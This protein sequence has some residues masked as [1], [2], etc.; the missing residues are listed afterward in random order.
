MHFAWSSC[1]TEIVKIC[2][3]LSFCLSISRYADSFLLASCL[4][5]SVSLSLSLFFD[6]P[7]LTLYSLYTQ[8][9]PPLFLCR[10]ISSLLLLIM[11][12]NIRLIFQ[13]EWS[14]RMSVFFYFFPK[15]IFCLHCPLC[16]SIIFFLLQL[17]SC[18]RRHVPL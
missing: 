15:N 14:Q 10:Q 4:I 11:S 13:D 7:V 12:Q 18:R 9:N 3:F 2:V 16:C 5:F 17:L 6:S 1:Q 8:I